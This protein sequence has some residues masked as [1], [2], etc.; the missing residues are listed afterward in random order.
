MERRGSSSDTKII[1]LVTHCICGN[2]VRNLYENYWI[3]YL[4]E[5][6]LPSA[7]STRG[8]VA[9]ILPSTETELP[10]RARSELR[11]PSKDNRTGV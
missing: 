2:Y 9:S 10:T 11:H 3:R 7:T 8:T 4:W 1:G 6:E 5:L